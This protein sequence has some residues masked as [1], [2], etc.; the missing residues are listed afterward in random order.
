MTRDNEAAIKVDVTCPCSRSCSCSATKSHPKSG[1][2]T[3]AATP[4]S[5]LEVLNSK[6]DKAKN[7]PAVKAMEETFASIASRPPLPKAT[8]FT[9]TEASRAAATEELAAAISKHRVDFQVNISG[10]EEDS[11]T[12][13]QVESR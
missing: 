5:I 9:V 4:T 13:E 2:I 10:H 6:K 12:R 3:R 11:C 8:K 7:N 1:P